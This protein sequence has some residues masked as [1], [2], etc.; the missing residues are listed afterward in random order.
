MGRLDLI[1]TDVREVIK[2]NGIKRIGDRV[3]N[4]EVARSKH[5][6]RMLAEA[7]ASSS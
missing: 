5:R 7:A 3:V 6:H 2:H 4:V 1:Q